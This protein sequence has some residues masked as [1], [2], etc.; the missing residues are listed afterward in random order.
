LQAHPSVGEIYARET[1]RLGARVEPALFEETLR[2]VFRECVSRVA[3]GPGKRG[4]SDEQDATMWRGITLEIHRRI[5]ELAAVDYE[6][7]FLALYETFS[8]A[9]AWRL[10]PDVAPS[11]ARLRAMRIRLGVVSNWDSRLRRVVSGLGLDRLVDFVLISAEAGSR[12]PD[13]A[14]FRKALGRAGVDSGE[15]LH[16]GDLFEEDVVGARAAG[17]FPVLVDREGRNVRAP[18]FPMW[19][20]SGLSELADRVEEGTFPTISGRGLSRG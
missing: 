8:E 2:S 19:T 13:S 15:A 14:I 12:K 6:R 4:A 18:V 3:A 20:V 11:L 5:P 16:A 7:W 1:E 9:E 17:I 10:Y